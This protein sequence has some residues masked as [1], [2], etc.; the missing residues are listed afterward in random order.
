MA[1][2]LRIESI[3]LTPLSWLIRG[4]WP[5][6]AFNDQSNEL[7]YLVQYPSFFNPIFINNKAIIVKYDNNLYFPVFKYYPASTFNQE[8]FGEAHYR[9]LAIQFDKNNDE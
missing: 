8:G 9:N 3:S 6:G 7:G 5:S 1:G 4:M 2:C